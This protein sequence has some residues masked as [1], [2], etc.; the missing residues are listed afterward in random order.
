MSSL[1][2]RFA[3]AKIR[4][5]L[6]VGFAILIV[7][8]III[9]TE[10]IFKVNQIDRNLTTINDVNDLKQSYA[11]DWRGSVHDRAIALRDI[12]LTEDS[13]DVRALKNDM[14]R[15]RSNYSE[16]T[17][18]MQ[19]VLSEHAGSQKEQTMLERISAQQQ[20]VR[21]FT[22]K[23]LSARDAGNREGARA[24][25]LEQ[26]GPA[27]AQWLV[28]I[29]DYIDLQGRLNDATTT[30]A[31]ETASGFQ[32]DMVLL[33]LFSVIVGIF[34]A[35]LLSRQLLRELGAEPYEVK[36]FA[37]AVG[38]GDLTAPNYLKQGDQ[39]SI[40]AAQVAMAQQLQG[41]VAEVRTS[42]EAVVD[43]SEQIAAGNNDLSSRT[44]QQASALA[45]TA[46]AMEQLS[47]TVK[48]NA[49][50]SAQA[51]QEAAS[52]SST[53]T[54]GGEAVQQV[55]TTMN[56][57]NQS[58][59]EIA[60]II[61]TIDAIAF[62]TNI[63]ALNASVEAA[64]AGEH[65]RGFA[66]VASEVRKLAQRSADAARDINELISSNL[67]R[68]NNG[69]ARAEEAGE[70]TKE[71]VAA[72][73]RVTDIMQ[74]ISNASAEQSDGVQEVGQAVTEMDHVTQQNAGLVQESAK[75]AN[76]LRQNAHQLIDSMSNFKLPDTATSR[77]SAAGQSSAPAPTHQAPSALPESQWE[78]F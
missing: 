22:Q 12:V 24:V 65:G 41:I 62:Q 75:S 4:T 27:Y 14:Q 16:A 13:S 28:R 17:E 59:Q 52:A 18:G 20:T 73:A 33:T 34:I 48:Q 58:S 61:S 56:E 55:V 67:E 76:N 8:M 2:A 23:V 39:H 10:G 51:S 37:E 1:Y 74:E 44:E 31:R 64:R 9:A 50:N 32:L 68:V 19:K 57:L 15:L 43:D 72:I 53:A 21:N 46:S 69:N 71:I 38:R 3:N 29:N 70:S 25:L 36:K 45:Q 35:W 26:A 42:A 54:Q 60:G 49:D 30:K 63:L 5:R 47:S 78:S 77:I 11:V 40:M 7:L 6:T 66:V